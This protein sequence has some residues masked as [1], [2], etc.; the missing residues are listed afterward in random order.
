[1][2]FQALIGELEKLEAQ[3]AELQDRITRKLAVPFGQLG[4][5]DG[6]TRS[7]PIPVCNAM[8]LL[9][10]ASLA[11]IF[12]DG[13]YG[14]LADK[15][16]HID[17]VR[18][19]VGV[20]R[21]LSQTTSKNLLVPTSEFA[22]P[23]LVAALKALAAGPGKRKPRGRY[24]KEGLTAKQTE[25]VELLGIHKTKTKAAA[26]MRIS[27]ATFDGHHDAAMRKLGKLAVKKRPRTEQHP[28]DYRGQPNI[29]RDDAPPIEATP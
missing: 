13:R 6:V 11:G 15:L 2:T 29:S 26:A 17:T 23:R 4:V 8:R 3:E 24:A 18:G 7:I 10:Q 14:K 25:A 22:I 16:E 12:Q 9:S 28:I 1:M 19:I 27:R 5:I 20:L 21:Y